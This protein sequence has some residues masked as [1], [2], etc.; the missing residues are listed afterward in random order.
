MRVGLV[1]CGIVGRTLGDRLLRSSHPLTVHDTDEHQATSLIDSGARWAEC[2]RDLARQSELIVTSL[3]GPAEVEA[4]AAGDDGLWTGA[5]RGT[6][7]LE[8]STVG[9]DCV[10]A[11]ARSAASKGIR[12]LEG[13]ISGA[14]VDESG[15]RL[16]IWIGGNA[17]HF[18]L[19]RPVLEVL[20]DEVSY[21]GGMGNAQI[22][23]LVNNHVALSLAV[24]LGEALTLGVRAGVPLEILRPA[25]RHGTAQ[26]RMLDEMLPASVF[27]NNWKPGLRLD[28]AC[29]DLD[30]VAEL[31]RNNR[32]ESPVADFVGGRYRRAID[33]GWGDRSAHSVIRLAE[34]EAEVE[35][36]TA[37]LTDVGTGRKP[38]PEDSP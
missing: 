20:A 18:D 34:E 37:G 30:L 16:V 35:L 36:R 6:L 4:V 2:P 12:L 32:I 26:N 7:H 23:K 8:T 5:A 3:P 14:G 27:R 25:L 28:L 15:Y 11:L 31:A 24:V 9:P 10:R 13:A 17:D 21:C 38:P 33:R 22:T 1:G 29:K 19:A